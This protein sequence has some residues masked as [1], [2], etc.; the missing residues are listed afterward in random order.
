MSFV[1]FSLQKRFFDTLLEAKWY[2]KPSLNI[3]S[4]FGGSGT[5]SK[6]PYFTKI[7]LFR[8][9]FSFSSFVE[10]GFGFSVRYLS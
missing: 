10:S 4:F 7:Y 9:K 8:I 5:I 3:G 2:K 1:T 6:S